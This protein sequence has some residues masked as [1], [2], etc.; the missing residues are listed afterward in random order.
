MEYVTLGVFVAIVV[1]YVVWSYRR[2]GKGGIARHYGLEPGDSVRAWWSADFDSKIS[3]AE[4]V[5]VAA[6]GLLLGGVATVRP[7]G[8]SVAISE[9]DLLVLMVEGKDGK[10]SRHAF[11]PSDGL[12]VEFLGP[13]ERRVQGGPSQ[14]LRLTAPDGRALQ[15]AIHESARPHLEQWAAKK[16]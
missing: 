13:G 6:A 9:R 15:L 7:R 12:R 11:V 5:G 10:V 4:K 8:V 16:A 1:G 3:T 14:I 2:S